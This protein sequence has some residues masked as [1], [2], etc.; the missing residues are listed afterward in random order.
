MDD[1]VCAVAGIHD[2]YHGNAD[3]LNSLI[4]TWKLIIERAETASTAARALYRPTKDL[5]LDEGNSTSDHRKGKEI[6]AN[7]QHLI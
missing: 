1:R 6:N 2:R 7:L 4:V 5:F 3:E